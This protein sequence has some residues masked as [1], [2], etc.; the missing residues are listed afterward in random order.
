MRRGSTCRSRTRSPPSNMGLLTGCC[1]G[2]PALTWSDTSQMKRPA[3][4]RAGLLRFKY[5]KLLSIAFS[6]RED[7][8]IDRRQ[9]GFDH[10][11]LLSGSIRKVDDPVL[12]HQVAAIVNANHH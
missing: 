5:R 2:L 12:V 4:V 6:Q 10:G 1:E 7:L 11:Q 9:S 3:R 8:H